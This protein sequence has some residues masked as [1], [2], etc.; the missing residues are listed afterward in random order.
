[1]SESDT[2]I[3]RLIWQTGGVLVYMVIWW[4]WGQK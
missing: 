3:L 4:I 1:M 2:Q